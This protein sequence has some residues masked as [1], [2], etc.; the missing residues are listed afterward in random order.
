MNNRFG[1]IEGRLIKPPS[2]DLLQYFPPNWIDE[3]NIAK[4]LKF[5]FIEFFKDRNDNHV[6]PFFSKK[7]FKIVSDILNLKNFKSYSFC[8]DYFIKKN[9]LKYKYLKKYF[10]NMSLNLSI[11]NAKLYV[12]PLYEKSNLNK[13]NYIKFLKKINLISNIL[14]KNNILLAL[15]TD[16]ELKFI[17]FLFKKVKNKNL[18]LAY[19]TGNRVKKGINQ[20]EEISNLKNKIIHIHLKDKDS[21]GNNVVLGNGIVNFKD[22][23][24]ALKKINYKRKF[25]FETNRGTDPIKTMFNNIKFIKKISSFVKYKIN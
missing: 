3:I 12:L 17:N 5:G 7:G 14:N 15:E 8:D 13:N 16:L 20:F 18:Y 23:F 10:E 25:C 4:F 6:S 19:D 9:F 21:Q 2:K 11:I 24:F 22:I 1:I